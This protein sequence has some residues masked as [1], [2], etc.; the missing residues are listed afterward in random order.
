MIVL[1][2]LV[3]G[4]SG[5]VTA[6]LTGSYLSDYAAELARLSG[7]LR[8]SEER[9]RSEPEA[10]DEA[11]SAVREVGF[12]SAVEIHTGSG[13]RLGVFES[14]S[15]TGSGVV[16]T[17]DGWILASPSFLSAADAAL[18]T[19]VVGR[20]AY[21]VQTVV[22]DSKTGA[23]FL[24]VDASNLPVLVFGEV[25]ELEAGDTLFVVTNRTS[26]L[27]TSLAALEQTGPLSAPSELPGR[28]LTLA[29]EVTAAQTG[30]AV[31]NGN[32][33][34]VGIMEASSPASGVARA[35]PLDSLRPAIHSLLSEGKIVRPYLG[36]TTLD[37]VR[38]VGISATISRG[39]ARGALV[40][41][42]ALGSPAASADLRVGDIVL[43]VNGAV[44]GSAWSLDE[45]FFEFKPGDT[46]FLLVD[47]L[48]A[49]EKV[50]V[51]LGA[52]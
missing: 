3:G 21:A 5:I 8:L 2:V 25:H 38:A 40:Q 45:Y 4:G 39:Y 41:A 10:L 18:A 34:L 20:E 23:M 36:L 13:G 24:K 26:L 35:I 52:M 17:S 15:A 32:G 6:A 29:S 28:R 22:K 33:E 50:D 19:V 1:S 27:V 16:L 49:Q 42:V 9:P 43:E 12:L 37:L 44:V 46:V 30:S 48:G 14:A 47:R 31:L 7:P 51:T 11:L